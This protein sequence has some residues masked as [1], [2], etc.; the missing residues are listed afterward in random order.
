[1]FKENDVVKCI[2]NSGCMRDVLV[3]GETYTI[4]KT[5]EDYIRL[6]GVSYCDWILSRRFVL[7]QDPL[8]TI[9]KPFGELPLETKIALFKAWLVGEQILHQPEGSRVL[10]PARVVLWWPTTIYRVAPKI[11]PKTKDSIDWSAVN[12][13][14]RYLRRNQDGTARLFKY[15]PTCC[16]GA[17]MISIDDKW[18]DAS[19]FASYKQGTEDWDKAGIDRPEDV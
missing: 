5:S 4:V 7:A 1:M 2:D 14:Y 3:L 12:K 6:F 17:W 10:M 8:T 15:L 13:D 16:G 19:I 11:P 9:D 18:M